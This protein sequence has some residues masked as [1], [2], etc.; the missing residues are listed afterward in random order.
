MTRRNLATTSALLILSA[1]MPLAFAQQTPPPTSETG[2]Q[3]QQSTDAA[4]PAAAPAKKTWSELD[5][6]K[7]GSLS[8]EEAGNIPSLQAVFDQADSNADGALTG[9]E[10]KTYLASNGKGQPKADTQR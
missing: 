10:Y 2:A 5:T 3:P 6:D 4:T 8:K 1:A 9:E 7:N